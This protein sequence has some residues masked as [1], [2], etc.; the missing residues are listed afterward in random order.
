MRTNVEKNVQ[1]SPLFRLC[2]LINR[3]K[4]ALL[5]DAFLSWNT[6]MVGNWKEAAAGIGFE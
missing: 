5:Y 6:V 4:V 1:Q 3:V 2:F